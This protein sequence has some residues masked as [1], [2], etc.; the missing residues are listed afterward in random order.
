MCTRFWKLVAYMHKITFHIVGVRV[1]NPW[2]PIAERG[3]SGYMSWDPPRI[4]RQR[5][6][7]I[8]LIDK[9]IQY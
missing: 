2:G 7:V 1:R 9:R 4:L 3:A 5:K 6:S 8:P